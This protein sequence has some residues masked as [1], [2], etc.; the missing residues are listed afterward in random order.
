MTIPWF[1]LR[2]LLSR[3]GRAYGAVLVVAAA[4]ALSVTVELVSRAREAAIAIQ[5]DAVG[6]ALRI[7][8]AGATPHSIVHDD[9]ASPS[10]LP[11][12][13]EGVRRMAGSDLAAL[14]QRRVAWV[15]VAGRS[16]LVIWVEPSPRG[17]PVLHAG[18]VALGPALASS[19]GVHAGQT[20]EIL[21]E[22]FRIATVLPSRANADDTAAFVSSA[23]LRTRAEAPVHP[24]ELRVYLRPEANISGLATEIETSVAGI[25]VLRPDRGAVVESEAQDALATHRNLIWWITGVVSLACLAIASHLDAQERRREVAMLV[26]IGAAGYDV[27]LTGVLRSAALGAAGGAIGFALGAFATIALD[28]NAASSVLP[29]L[30]LAAS[31]IAAATLVG[32]A[33]ALPTGTAAALR[34]PVAELQDV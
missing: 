25:S 22:P 12:T 5:L 26:A 21:G 11:G 28:A 17:D 29:A 10:L 24:T 1:V 4:V 23:A 6:P 34:D 14:E 32:I 13:V 33:A 16:S 31:A 27:M 2:E 7:L 3:R 20:V 15:P 9:P 19:L 30:P 18:E 8:P